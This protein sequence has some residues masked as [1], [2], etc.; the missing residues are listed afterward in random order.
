MF[1]EQYLYSRT[2]RKNERSA[3]RDGAEGFQVSAARPRKNEEASTANGNRED[4][5]V[6]GPT[7][8]AGHLKLDFGLDA[9]SVLVVSMGDSFESLRKY[10]WACCTSGRGIIWLGVKCDGVIFSR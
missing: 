3:E 8:I 2:K 7:A 5:I 10:L 4:S 1:A 6:R 9:V